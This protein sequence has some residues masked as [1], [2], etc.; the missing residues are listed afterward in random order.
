MINRKFV[1]GALLAAALVA[2]AAWAQTVLKL[3]WTT[4]D[5]ADDPYAMG[6]RAFQ[7]SLAQRLGDAV[8]VQLYP[9]RQLGDEKQLL[10]GLRLG[11]VEAAVITNAV[12]AQLEPALQL[13]DL[14]FLY[15][16]PEQAHGVLDGQVG[17]Q[18]A[19]RLD[20]R[21]IVVLGY[22][23]GGFRHMLNNR[24]PVTQPQD[25]AGVKYRVMQNPV[26]IDMFNAMGG[27][28]V[29]MAWG[30]TYTAVQQGTIDGLEIPLPVVASNKYQEVTKFLSLTGHSYSTNLLLISKR[31]LNRLPAEQRAALRQ[32]GKDAT[33]MQRRQNAEN[34]DR[35]L[36]VL[37]QGMQVNRLA[38]IAPF[39]AA[40]QPIYDKYRARF[41]AELIDQAL[42]AAP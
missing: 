17:Q 31:A 36:A 33:L 22:M 41:G 8:T 7:Q 9:N 30:E 37:Q 26:F 15:A 6:A 19:E 3:G 16:S 21:G 32:A 35:L 18:L 40:V 24:R 4:A 20:A 5:S 23:E 34:T 2:P 42:R 25:V 27:S 10:E 13:N 28:A 29:P 39:Q 11:T 1:W 12:V 38:S 14:P